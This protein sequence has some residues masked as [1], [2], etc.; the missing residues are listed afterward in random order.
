MVAYFKSF[1][2]GVG[3]VFV[4]DVVFDAVYDS[5]RWK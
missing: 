5:V 3:S 2:D 1:A 4:I